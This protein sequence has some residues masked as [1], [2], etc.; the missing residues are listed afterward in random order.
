[1]AIRRLAEK[2]RLEPP[3]R[4]SDIRNSLGVPLIEVTLTD[5]TRLTQNS[6]G[7]VLGTVENPMSR[8]QVI[9]K[10]RSLIQPVIGAAQCTRLIDGVL[11]MENMKDVRGLRPLLQ[12]SSPGGAPRLSDYPMTT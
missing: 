2:V 12:W 10:S 5:G 6:L 4:G 11:G 9:A 7:P 1:P 3:A 8:D